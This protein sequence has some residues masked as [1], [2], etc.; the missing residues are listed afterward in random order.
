MTRKLRLPQL[1][2][3]YHM[4]KMMRGA[5]FSVPGAGKT[6][7]VYGAFAYLES[8]GEVDKIV[9]VGPINSF[10]S[11]KNEFLLCFGNKK[12]LKVFDY[13]K[14]KENNAQDRFDKIVFEASKKN[15]ILFNYESLQSNEDALTSLIDSKTLLVFDE[16]HRIK[17]IKGI[18]AQSARRIGNNSKYRIVLTGTPIPNGYVDLYNVLNIELLKIILW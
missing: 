3:A 6:S 17:A 14:E 16:V 1:W 9:M 13:Q 15:L 12:A 10:S 4:A 2:D 11:W 5:N 18:R 7:I 8:L